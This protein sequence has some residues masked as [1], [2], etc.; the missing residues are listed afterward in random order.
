[1]LKCK[2]CPQKDTTDS[3]AGVSTIEVSNMVLK[4]LKKKC[5]D[6]SY[7]GIGQDVH[8]SDDNEFSSFKREV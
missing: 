3:K 2:F 1:M 8:A 6:I 5:D 4:S 7:N